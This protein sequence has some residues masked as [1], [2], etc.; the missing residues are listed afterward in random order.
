[1][2]RHR[3]TTLFLISFFYIFTLSAFVNLETRT[4]LNAKFTFEVL[5]LVLVIIYLYATGFKKK[6][7]IVLVPVII[8]LFIALL[9]FIFDT[10]NL[11]LDDFLLIYKSYFY[12]LIMTLLSNRINFSY[13]FTKKLLRFL[14]IAFFVKYSLMLTLDLAYQGRPDL[15]A[16]NNFELLL[17]LILFVGVVDKSRESI[18][19]DFLLLTAVIG[20]SGSLSASACY[21]GIISILKFPYNRS[22]QR[23]KFFILAGSILFL[24]WLLI[25]RNVA[26]ENIDRIKF[27]FLFLQEIENWGMR[28]F[29]FGSPFMTPVSNITANALIYYDTLFSSVENRLAYSVLF[30]S[31][32][33][34]IIFDH[35]FVGLTFIVWAVHKLAS[36][37]CC[38]MQVKLCILMIML[39]AGLSISSFNSVFAL[40]GI[41]I[42]LGL[43]KREAKKAG[44]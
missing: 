40:F 6:L 37:N 8:Y 26:F 44:G 27:L 39:L 20:M 19:Q 24:F 25:A 9:Q 35:G 17:L 22:I 33:L 21:A 16:E 34:R 5:I 13:N 43:N 42:V 32:V 36:I 15:Y 14:L 4:V 29:L 18:M 2:S 7:I 41:V 30:H 23:F 1:M 10:R 11:E 28:E 31:F 12:I 38:S 3:I